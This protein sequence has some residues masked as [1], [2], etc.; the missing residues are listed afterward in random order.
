MKNKKPAWIKM[1]ICLSEVHFEVNLNYIR[2][3][4][5]LVQIR[6]KLFSAFSHS[7]SEIIQLNTNTNC[8]I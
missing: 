3:Q 8:V 6:L 1:D 5:S 4:T 2:T 7:M